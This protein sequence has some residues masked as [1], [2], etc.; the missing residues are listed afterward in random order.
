MNR[1]LGSAR[2]LRSVRALVVAVV[3]VGILLPVVQSGGVGAATKKTVKT[4]KKTSTPAP[5]AVSLSQIQG[6][7]EQGRDTRL[8]IDVTRAAGFTGPIS[9]GM[10]QLPEGVKAYVGQQPMTGN[11]TTFRLV[12]AANA[13]LAEA[14][15]KIVGSSSGRTSSANLS[16]L[17]SPPSTLT[18]SAP[19]V[20]PTTA[21]AGSPTTVGGI[22]PVVPTTVAKPAAPTSRVE[23]D[24]SLTLSPSFAAVPI[25]ASY[26]DVNVNILRTGGF[27]EPLLLEAKDLPPGIGVSFLTNPATGDVAVARFTASQALS[28]PAKVTIFSRG[29]S[30]T[31]EISTTTVIPV[32]TTIPA[33]SQGLTVNPAT[34]K[35]S[36][37]STASFVVSLA[38]SVPV[39]GA[40]IWSVSGLPS[41][42]SG[43]YSQNGVASSSNSF[44]LFTTAATP[45]GTYP[46][47][48]N[49]LVGTVTY[50]GTATVTIGI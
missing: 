45:V 20:P 22:N 25:G 13:P 47:S 14:T 38:S 1:T 7:V 16:I 10:S 6:V 2:R 23:I 18:T 12:A 29:R 19:T 5:F 3:A 31:I 33:A 9:L 43:S 15:V 21:L 28:T 4:T 42:A 30:A 46:I 39:T 41:A 35:V 24:Y 8:T 17:V 34:I 36:P 40:T 44:S 32:S 48:F 50:F 27:A 49:V 26:V 11:S 37:G